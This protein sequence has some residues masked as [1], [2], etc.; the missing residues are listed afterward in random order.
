MS[1]AALTLGLLLAASDPAVVQTVPNVPAVPPGP[2]YES[3]GPMP[4]G[5]PAPADSCASSYERAQEERNEG[6]LRAA[7]AQLLTCSQSGCPHFVAR[8]CR[9]WLDEVEAALPTVV[10][11]ARQG[12]RDLETVTVHRLAGGRGRDELLVSHLDGRALPMDP[13]KQSFSFAT[14]GLPPGRV[15]VVIAEGQKRRLIEVELSP[16]AAG[17]DHRTTVALVLAGL[18]TAGVAG[19]A[20][21]GLAGWRQEA[22][23]EERCAP[24]CT[25]S[26]VDDVRRRYRIADISLGVGLASLAAAGYLYFTTA[27]AADAPVTSDA[28]TISWFGGPGVGAISLGKSF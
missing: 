12:G 16:T 2:A 13:G 14:P 21:F 19:F 9:R 28:V 1:V 27:R 26:E 5:P 20:G 17:K 22:R 7:R 4:P 25:P 3:P 23:L 15:D 10:F 11:I 6:R 18:G 24:R 8:D